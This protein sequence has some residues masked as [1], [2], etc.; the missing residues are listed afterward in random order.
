MTAYCEN[1]RASDPNTVAT[2]GAIIYVLAQTAELADNAAT[3]AVRANCRKLFLGNAAESIVNACGPPAAAD[4]GDDDHNVRAILANANSVPN[5]LADLV[6][7]A[8]KKSITEGNVEGYFAQLGHSG[9][10]A[11][12]V[13][14]LINQVAPF[15]PDSVGND[16]F[17]ALLAPGMWTTYRNTRVSS[18]AIILKLLPDF[19]LLRITTEG[20]ANEALIT[21][22]AN[23]PWSTEAANDIPV[24]FRGYACIFLQAAGT[25]IDGWFQGNNAVAEMPANRVRGAKSIFRKYLEVK[26]D[27]D[28]DELDTIAKF[29]ASEDVRN[30]F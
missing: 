3:D 29:T 9:T 10:K 4:T 5:W 25:P 21:A 1:F 16:A 19:R 2:I 22:A 7:A 14:R 17:R 11:G 23:A 18:G 8:K 13:A 12:S 27:V 6:N 15:F 30:F 24:K 28:V 26:N 20:D